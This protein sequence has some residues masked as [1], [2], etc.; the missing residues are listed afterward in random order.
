MIA[1]LPA[2]LQDVIDAWPL[3]LGVIALIG[4]VG[5]R[6]RAWVREIRHLVRYHLGPN[7]E[8]KAL[9]KRVSDIEKANGIEDS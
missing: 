8:T 3:V 9:H 4:W 1:K 7:G 5:R 6:Q 2:A